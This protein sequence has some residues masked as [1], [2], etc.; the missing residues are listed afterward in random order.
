MNDIWE[1]LFELAPIKR[2]KPPSTLYDVIVDTGDLAT[3]KR[4]VAGGH[5][6]VQQFAGGHSVTLA[7]SKG[8]LELVRYFVEAADEIQS[9]HELVTHAVR[10]CAEANDEHLPEATSI[11]DYILEQPLAKSQLTSGYLFSAGVAQFSAAQKILAAGLK[12]H[13]IRVGADE[14]QLLSERVAALGN[15]DFATLLKDEA[16]DTERLE[17]AEHKERRLG[18]KL[19][20][21]L[22]DLVPFADQEVLS[23]ADFDAKYQALLEAVQVG[24][25]DAELDARDSRFG[26]SILE[27][28]AANGFVELVEQVLARRKLAAEAAKSIGREAAIAAATFG[29]LN[30][31]EV[32]QANDVPVQQTAPGKNSPLSEACRFGHVDVVRFLLELGADPVSGDGSGHDLKLTDIAGGEQRN[33]I[34]AALE[35]KRVQAS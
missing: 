8:D 27:F 2:S 32:L 14:Y 24:E 34:I 12:D 35:E 20:G 7:V 31:L 9:I 5:A 30:V 13:D 1:V 18:A 16:V 22:D 28:A 21:T 26:R 15:P 29:N 10:R 17:Q 11:L 23:G 6:A 4:Y 25:R 3:V 33:E 19:R